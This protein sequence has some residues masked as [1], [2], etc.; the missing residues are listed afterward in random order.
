MK[1]QHVMVQDTLHQIKRLELLKEIV[2]KLSRVT[3]FGTSTSAED[4][5]SLEV[6]KLAAGAMKVQLQYLDVLTAKDI[7][8]GFRAATKARADAVLWAVS[9]SVDRPHRPQITDSR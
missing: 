5:K 9:G 7:D 8:P 1:C 4:A 2:P 3:V 6:I